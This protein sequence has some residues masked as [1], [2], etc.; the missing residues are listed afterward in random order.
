MVQ[1]FVASKRICHQS[2]K[3]YSL[4]TLYFT[5]KFSFLL[6]L[7]FHLFPINL[8]LSF[9]LF[10]TVIIHF[11]KL[12]GQR[13]FFPKYLTDIFVSWHYWSVFLLKFSIFQFKDFK[14]SW[15]SLYICLSF[16]GFSSFICPFTRSKPILFLI[17][18]NNKC[19]L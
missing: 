2:S 5:F 17:Q 18:N 19:L 16:W 15:F 1:L 4:T 12:L 3:T 13:S 14:M 7:G 6:Y 11:T 10:K 9:L 8:L